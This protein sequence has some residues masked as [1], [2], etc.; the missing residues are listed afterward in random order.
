[1]NELMDAPNCRTA[2][3]PVF[4]QAVSALFTGAKSVRGKMPTTPQPD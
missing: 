3:S 1:M 4:F 2:T